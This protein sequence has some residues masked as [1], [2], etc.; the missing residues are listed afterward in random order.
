VLAAREGE[1]AECGRAERGDGDPEDDPKGVHVRN[2]A[3]SDGLVRAKRQSHTICCGFGDARP[4]RVVSFRR[5][6]FFARGWR[7]RRPAPLRRTAPLVGVGHPDNHS[8]RY[9]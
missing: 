7:A 8:Y 6:L 3:I 9:E 5:K 1:D 4:L 2:W